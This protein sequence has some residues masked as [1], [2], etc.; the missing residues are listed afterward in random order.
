MWREHR[1]LTLV[2]HQRKRNESGCPIFSLCLSNLMFPNRH[3]DDY[4]HHNLTSVAM[5][6]DRTMGAVILVMAG[7][8]NSEGK[9]ETTVCI[10]DI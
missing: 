9:L 1:E 5:N 3:G 7:R 4:F 10:N 6:L 8:I 2:R